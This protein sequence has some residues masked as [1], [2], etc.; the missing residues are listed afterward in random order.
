[1][2]NYWNRCIW[3]ILLSILFSACGNGDIATPTSGITPCPPGSNVYVSPIS[4]NLIDLYENGVASAGDSTAYG[5]VQ[6]QAFNELVNHVYY[7]SDSVDIQSG[8][9]T[10]RITIT[11]ISPELAHII[12]VN[13]YLYKRYINFSGKFKEQVPNHVS[14]MIG[15]NEYVFFITFT[16]SFYT[17]NPKSIIIFPLKELK[18]INTNNTAVTPVHDDHNFEKPFDLT[19]GPRYGFFYYPMAIIQNGPCQ[20]VLDRNYDTSIELSVPKVFINEDDMGSHSWDYK[21]APLI[22]M[23]SVSGAHQNK[24]SLPLLIDQFVPRTSTLTVMNIESQDFWAALARIIWA[25]TTLDP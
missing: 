3:L 8:E 18:L 24:F 6:L 11:Y 22:D 12:L 15:R 23:T 7:L 4:Q 14:R 16:A 20:T 9:K 10:V 2:N 19:N 13:H 17:D 25:E 1:M 5:N 21:L